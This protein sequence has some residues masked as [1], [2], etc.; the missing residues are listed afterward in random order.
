V[1]IE[2]AFVLDDAGLTQTVTAENLS[3]TAAPVG[4]SAH[5][6]LVGGAG[7]VDEW[8]LELPAS[9]ILDVTSDR[10]IPTALVPVAERAALDFRDARP[11]ADT[12]IDHAYTDL[13]RDARGRAEARVTDASGRGVA[14]AWG[15][16]CA[17]VQVHTADR[18]AGDRDNRV[19]LAV[20][21]MTCAPDAFNADRYAWDT[22]LLTV[23]PG[24]AVEASWT[25]SAF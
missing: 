15:P 14:I 12:A 4:L 19:G 5:P 2:T 9:A 21:P 8:M 10:L 23:A 16:E 20:E 7:L 3:P 24:A 18:P 13:A 6:Y 17:W 22:G 25:I 11:I 1:R